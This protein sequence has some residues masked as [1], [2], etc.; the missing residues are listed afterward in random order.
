MG[1]KIPSGTLSIVAEQWLR[2]GCL[3]E[4]WDVWFWVRSDLRA[5]GRSQS[6]FY[7]NAPG[8]EPCCQRP[9]DRGG[10]KRHGGCRVP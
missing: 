3:G 2:L 8:R 7:I 4:A 6:E 10:F 1:V 9:H 5:F